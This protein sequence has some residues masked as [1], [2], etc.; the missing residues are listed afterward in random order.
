LRLTAG[1]LR[2]QAQRG[3]IQIFRKTTVRVIQFI[4]RRSTLERKIPE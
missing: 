4:E 3:V 1:W 2:A